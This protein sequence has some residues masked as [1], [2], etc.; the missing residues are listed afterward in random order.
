MR[1]IMK[2]ISNKKIRLNRLKLYTALSA[3]LIA[4]TVPSFAATDNLI[5][6]GSFEN[7]TVSKDKGNW[8]LVQFDH[9]QG[10][11]EVWTSQR[12]KAATEGEYKI[13][14]DVGKEVNTLSQSV[15]TIAGQ[16]YHLSLD[17]YARRTDSSDFEILLDGQIITTITPYKKWQRYDAYFIGTGTEQ[18]LAIKEID[19][20][21][22]GLGTIIDNITLKTSNELLSN[23]SFEEFTINVDHGK[24]KEVT[25]KDWQG[26]GEVWNHRTGKAATRGAYKIELDVGKEIN[27]LSQAVTTEEGLYYELS[28]DAYARRKNTSDFEIWV[29][30]QKIE[31]ITFTKAKEWNRYSVRFLGNGTSQNIILK[32]LDSQNNGF[33]TVIDAVSLVSTGEYLNSAPIISGIPKTTVTTGDTYTF[34]PEASDENPDD[35]LVFSIENKPEWANFDTSTGILTGTP[36]T[37]SISNTIIISVSDGSKTAS[38]A[39]F[40]I[41]VKDAVNVARQFGVATQTARN[42]YYYYSPPNNALDG[43]SSTSNHTQCNAG[44]NWWQVALPQPTNISKFII[45]GRESNAQRLN[46]AEVYITSSPYNGTLNVDDKVATLAGTSI[47]QETTFDTEKTGNY[48]IVKASGD[49][50]LHLAEVEVYGSMPDTPVF[51]SHATDFLIKGSTAIGDTL[52]SLSASDYQADDLSYRIVGDT[53]FAID[54]QG[55]ITVSETLKAGSYSIAVEVSDGTHSSQSTLSVNVTSNTAVDDAIK[56]GSVKQVTSE[57]LL[58]AAIAEIEI[59]KRGDSLLT[60]LYG[61]EPIAYT[62]SKSSQ[63]I[64]IEGDAHKIFPI[65]YG[66]GGEILAAAGEKSNSRFAAFGSVPMAHFQ[67]GENLSFQT[68]MQQLLLWLTDASETENK[69]VALSFAHSATDTKNWLNINYPNWTIKECN[70]VTTLSSCLN[71]VDLVIQGAEGGNAEAIKQNL[72]ALLDKGTAILY[73]HSSWGVNETAAAISKLFEFSLPY[74]GNWWAKDK[75]DWTTAEAMQSSYFAS[76]GYESIAIMLTHFQQKDYSFNWSQC[77]EE[78]CRPVSGLDTEFQQGAS[79]VRSLLNAL[80]SNKKNIFAT[81]DYYLQKLLALIGDK[82]RQSVSYPMD[83]VTSDDT[84]FMQ[85]YYADHAVYNYRNINPAQTD[86]GNFS[87]S[88]FSHITPITKTVNLTSKKSFR[89]TGAY[90][91]PGQTVSVTRNDQSDLTVKVFI[92]TLRSGATHQY[93]ENGYKRPKYLKTPYIE[94]KS[95]ETIQLTSPYGGPIQ[96]QFST[97]DLPVSVTFDNVGEH[98]YWASPADD[99]TFTTKLAA[100]EFD[101]AE[102]VTTGFEVHSKLDK[103]Q[104][105]VARPEWGTARAL[106]NATERYMS[107]FPHVLAGFKGPGIDIVDEIHDF[108][109]VNNLTIE[110]LD[111]VKHMNADQATCGYGCSGNPYDAYWAYSPIGHGDVHELGHGLEKSRFR[112]EGW[113]GHSTTNPYSYYTKSKYNQTTGGDPSCQKL[114][115]KQV[116]D[117]LQASVNS[118]NVTE[119]LKA[120]LWESSGWSQQFMVTLQAMMHTQKMGKLEN[121]WHLLARL[122][123]LERE[124]QRAKQD[125]ESQKTNIG[126]AN[127]TLA[128]FDD[129][130]NNDWLLIS[131]SFASGLDFS[132]YL[133]MMGIE[134]SSKA[135]EQ[136]SSFGYPMVAKT[137]FISTETGYC[138]TDT[139]G[140]YLNKTTLAIDGQSIWSE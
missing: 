42:G 65:L 22:N 116:F 18:T 98:A 93:Q 51:T 60:T 123:I 56:S 66:E 47:Q 113:E 40:A 63:H 29:D 39:A 85:S 127:Y 102:V 43:D 110:T 28:L 88:D 105:S 92:N 125:W 68:G 34:T 64:N 16:K 80:D 49:N 71:D 36:N 81:D 79:K 37:E 94:V 138:K 44:E 25:F 122:H 86:M 55:N 53:P 3:I 109:T 132:D 74:G 117:Q 58:T 126:F 114:P 45:Q 87:R 62:P 30:D 91:L 103:M 111:K 15:T 4:N 97:N 5:Q 78:D 89:S 7:F 13:E 104:E 12:G 75:A 20:Q 11:G 14:L 137:F 128:E 61:N 136:V 140:D 108:A 100:A 31:T 50:C 70:D 106:A 73:L 84:T 24:W 8:K 21:S 82:F 112:F 19:A 118:D 107:N 83:K 67:D 99:N 130:E 41:Q 76:F 23:G 9:W 35:S 133:D 96:L 32:E 2:D 135:A 57:E 77:N 10:D 72:D 90:A 17:A 38:L 54:A 115:F 129:I 120:N 69:T 95:G 124:I 131:L 119:Y 121:G 33:G 26:N 101:W 134:Y 52:V 6:N 46:A 59:L 139:Y 27:S 48:L 1:L